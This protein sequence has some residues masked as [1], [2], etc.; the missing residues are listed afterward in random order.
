V[1]FSSFTQ[2]AL[3]E[4]QPEIPLLPIPCFQPLVSIKGTMEE[5]DAALEKLIKQ[6]SN[7][8]LD[9]ELNQ[10]MAD[11][12]F[13]ESIDQLLLNSRLEVRRLRNRKLMER[14]LLGEEGEED[15]E[16]LD[17]A[18]VFIRCLDQQEI[19]E[20]REDLILCHSEIL[21]QIQEEDSRSEEEQDS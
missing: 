2:G 1:D 12:H 20:N 10:L 18:A 3:F 8:W 7:A 6:N 11:E 13:R 9:I 19:Q 5:I 4:E 21:K 16:I 17:P 15:L 14:A